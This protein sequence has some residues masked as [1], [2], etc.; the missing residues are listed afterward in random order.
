MD[1]QYS[2]VGMFCLGTKILRRSQYT[3]YTH[4][5]VT[6]FPDRSEGVGQVGRSHFW[7]IPK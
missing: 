2:K 6:S 1:L 4:V 7:D 5:E 3:Q